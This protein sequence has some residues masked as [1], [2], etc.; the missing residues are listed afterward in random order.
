M[1]SYGLG[2]TRA[3]LAA[4][5]ALELVDCTDDAENFIPQLKAYI[6]D[7]WDFEILLTHDEFMDIIPK[8]LP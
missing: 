3:A 2:L 7:V 5:L 8:A 6:R 1:F 4:A